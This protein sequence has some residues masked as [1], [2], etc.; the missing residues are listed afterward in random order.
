VLDNA[1]HMSAACARVVDLIVR[2]CPGARVVVTS[3]RPLGLAAEKVIGLA[4]LTPAATAELL[5]LRMADHVTTTR[6]SAD[7]ESMAELCRLIEGLPLAVELAAE[8]L[9]TM[10]L[11]A[12]L[13][14]ITVRPDLLA[15][16]GR[17]GPAHQRGL[18]STLR[19]SYDLLTPGQRLLLG[20]LGVVAGLFDLQH[21][22]EICSY[23]PL[24]KGDVA[25]ML[26][27]LADDSLVQVIRDDRGHWYR[28]L[29]PIR[30]FAISQAD[31]ED[32]ETARARHLR[33][34]S[35]TAEQVDSAD[36]A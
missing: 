4:P 21:A 32:L 28:L 1:E 35:A 14:R 29:V 2:C 36:A 17:P 31:A 30:D 10:S 5:H 34:L 11:P 3:R 7:R 19:W 15:A 9:R 33:L 8:R 6:N 22:E 12:L 27:A 26:S 16:P 25:G 23:D 13:E 20:R 24:T 18:T